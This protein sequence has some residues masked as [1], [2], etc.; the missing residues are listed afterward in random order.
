[1]PDRTIEASQSQSA[2]IQLSIAA[3]SLA[4]LGVVFGDIGTSPLY[5]LKTH[6]HVTGGAASQPTAIL[7]RAVADPV[8]A[9]HRHLAEIRLHRLAFGQWWRR[10]H[11]R[12]GGTSAQGARAEAISHHIYGFDRRCARVW[13]RHDHAGN[14]GHVGSGGAENGSTLSRALC[15]ASDRGDPTRVVRSAAA[16]H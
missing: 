8:D 16:R 12:T 13:R 4:A 1:M 5:T 6:Q 3:L 15:V 9:D 14:F 2:P 10:R 7:R 11:S